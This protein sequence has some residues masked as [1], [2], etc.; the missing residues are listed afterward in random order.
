MV[1]ARLLRLSATDVLF[2]GTEILKISVCI[3]ISLAM[4]T[5]IPIL[6]DS[7]GAME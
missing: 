5:A 3:H 6:T 1:Y 2:A 7:N 4:V